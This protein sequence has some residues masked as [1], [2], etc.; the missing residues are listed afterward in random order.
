MVN[1]GSNPFSDAVDFLSRHFRT[2]ESRDSLIP[3]IYG[4]EGKNTI[5]FEGAA[6]DFSARLVGQLPLNLLQQVLREIPVG[7][8]QQ[9][10]VETLCGRLESRGDDPPVSDPLAGLLTVPPPARGTDDGPPVLFHA[11][12]MLTPTGPAQSFREMLAVEHPLLLVTH[13]AADVRPSLRELAGHDRQW[14]DGAAWLIPDGL[15]RGD[16]GSHT[17]AEPHKAAEPAL[18]KER[19]P[20]LLAVD[21]SAAPPEH[22][23]VD[24]AE[25]S[26]EDPT[27]RILDFL[28][29]ARTR[30]HQVVLGMP[31]FALAAL[32][33]DRLRQASVQMLTAADLFSEEYRHRAE[34][35]EERLGRKLPFREVLHPLLSANSVTLPT[36]AANFLRA[37]PAGRSWAGSPIDDPAKTTLALELARGLRETGFHEI[38]YR[39]EGHCRTR[40]QARGVISLA[41]DLWPAPDAEPDEQVVAFVESVTQAPALTRHG[42]LI[43]GT[44]AGKTTSL[45]GIE[46]AWFLPRFEEHGL[47]VR[48]HLPL[49][50]PLDTDPECDLA[51]RVEAHVARNAFASFTYRNQRYH[52]PCHD[53]VRT[54]GK[55]DHLHWLFSSPLYLLLDDV[56]RLSAPARDRLRADLDTLRAGASDTGTLLACR[57]ERTALVLGSRNMTVRE[58]SEQQVT[59]LLAQRHGDPTLVDLLAAGGGSVSRHLR[60]PQLLSLLCELRATDR[61]LR[62]ANLRAILELYVGRWHERLADPRQAPAVE[63]WLAR[64]ALALKKAGQ[65]RVTVRPEDGEAIATG[66]L[67]GLLRDTGAPDVAEFRFD[68]L[69]DY[70]A[71]RQLAQGFHKAGLA[72][73]V[74]APEAWEDV[75]RI[76]VALLPGK[77]AERLVELL[78]RGGALRLA[79]EC[80]LELAAPG[81]RAV[82]ATVPALLRKTARDEKDSFLGKDHLLRI[83]DVRALGR[84]DPRVSVRSPLRN[85]VDVPR[86]GPVE[87]FRIGRYPVTNMEFAEFV[88]DGGYEQRAWWDERGWAWIRKQKIRFP[89]YWLNSRLNAPNQPVTGVNFFE[90]TAYCAWLTERNGGH[91]FRLPSAAEWD[92][93][94]HG[95]LRI[96]HGVLGALVP[97][98]QPARPR[99]LRLFPR[100]ER[101]GESGTRA[102][103]DRAET[104]EGLVKAVKE[105]MDQMDLTAVAP[106]YGPGLPVG[107]LPP[108]TRGVH[109]LFGSVWQWCNTSLRLM[110]ATEQE[111]RDLA[112]GPGIGPAVSIV[113]KGGVTPP[114]HSPVWSLIGG[115][116]DPHVRFHQLGFRVTCRTPQ[117][118]TGAKG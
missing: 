118:G 10:W 5:Q 94:A 9:E 68:L 81:Q 49:Y 60:N 50:V 12:P 116:F 80:V 11:T 113:V 93:A 72:A 110:S 99:R 34:S 27:A 42:T 28:A 86:T 47:R 109:D 83:D 96:F 78:V 64:V 36:V 39:L 69:R 104:V 102:P 103:V 101:H 20:T 33:T 43:G 46:H 87:P 40:P 18:R 65:H 4:W 1:P 13:F 29:W 111:L 41:A 16:S 44:G 45:L 76:L 106:E 15:R 82:G 112:E 92:S 19:A 88:G 24:R 62:N 73:A 55:L 54:V 8:E 6:K 114:S 30:G 26:P 23:L 105:H 25:T 79:H 52:L 21:F 3:L 17:G 7:V 63:D 100:A 75:L 58:L 71:A 53:L 67:L 59:E 89:R 31:R 95:R 77:D 70:F 90:A 38:A 14:L 74:D 85:L 51:G 56:D 37:L 107:L 98:E 32:D 22:V 66:R 91:L 2:R 117:G 61:T 115:W 97:A 35:C 84:L 48:H 57:T 108:N